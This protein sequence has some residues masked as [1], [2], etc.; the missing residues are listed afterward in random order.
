MSNPSILRVVILYLVAINVVTFLLYGIDK[1]KAKRSKW[2][3]P[4]S[5]LLGLAVIGGR[6]GAWLG[7]IVWRHKTQHKK[8][9]YGIPLI[10]AMQIAI[11]IMVSCKT[12]QAVETVK[13]LPENRYVPEHSP[14]VFLISYDA[15]TGKEPVLKA[16]K[17]YR[18][19]IVYDY[20]TF[21]G[22]ALKKPE[23]K[24]LEETM[25]YFRGVKGVLTVEYD[26]IT[27][28]DDPIRP[29]LEER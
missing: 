16:I 8:F 7:M 13:P 25:Q 4:E 12:E 9:R 2:R 23:D 10:L 1:F 28:L 29:K 21:N 27:R 3:I 26:Y 19:E 6:V 11:L 20:H 5:V 24:T 15:E 18:C 14:D 17:K 22:M